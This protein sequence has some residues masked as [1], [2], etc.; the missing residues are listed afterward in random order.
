VPGVKEAHDERNLEWVLIDTRS[1]PA[2]YLKVATRTYTM[3]D[4]ETA[5]WDILQGGRTVAM[6]AITAD[7]QVVLVRQFR[8]GPGRVLLELPG[9]NVEDGEDIEAAA[10]RELLEETGFCAGQIEIAGQTWLASYATH[11]RFAVIA[12]GCRRISP[13]AGGE[14]H[15]DALEFLEPV[16]VSRDDFLRHVSAGQLTDTD[17]AFM[18]LNRLGQV[19]QAAATVRSW[20]PG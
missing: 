19:P 7:E 6:V 13:E 17:I 16:L 12:T 8:P 15:A 14:V 9:G 20:L 18:C 5:D 4:G 1:G 2:G 11:Q 3:P 10:R